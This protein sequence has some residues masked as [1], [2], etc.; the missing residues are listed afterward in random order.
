[1]H[2]FHEHLQRGEA[3]G[4]EWKRL[5]HSL[6]R[7]SN[8][9]LQNLLWAF[10]NNISI[11]LGIKGAVVIDFAEDNSCSFRFMSSN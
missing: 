2:Q 4:E 3:V 5:V 1:M 8:S 10:A 7:V 6:N 11:S 9:A